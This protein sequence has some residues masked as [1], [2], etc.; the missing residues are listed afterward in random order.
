MTVQRSVAVRDAKNDVEETTIGTSP[1]LQLRTGAQPANCAAAATGTLLGSSSLPSDWL[2]NSSAGTKSK[3]GTW[4]GTASAA[5]TVGHY[6]ILDST[7]T[8]CHQQGTVFQT[9]SINTSAI[10]AAN[11]NVLTF[12]ATTGVVV[13]MLATGTGVAANS[14]VLATTA[15]TVTL[16][17]A[18][19]AGVA[20]GVAISFGGDMNIDNAVLA[21]SQ[22]YTVT[23]YSFTAAA[24]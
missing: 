6:R 7:G 23:A 14:T 8:T 17:A 3:N 18:S 11:S 4:A 5:G 10:T 21:V 15:T 16:S 2:T 19:T 24:A 12:A 9:V 13:G 22:A 20:S 1:I